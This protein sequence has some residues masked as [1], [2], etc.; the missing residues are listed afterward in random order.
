MSK[1][2]YSQLS[3]KGAFT[4]NTKKS[5]SVEQQ[6]Q[7]WQINVHFASLYLILSLDDI[8]IFQY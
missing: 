3:L 4:V 8:H 1:A 2:V 5:V 7:K 6:Y